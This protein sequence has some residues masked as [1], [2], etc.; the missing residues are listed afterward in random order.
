MLKEFIWKIRV[1]Y[2]DTD[3]GGVVFY[4]NYLRFM[5]RARTEWLR[6]IGFDHKNL[7]E[8]YKLIFAV[9]NLK[10]N[11]MK[12]GYLDDLLT[13]TSKLLNNRGASLVFQQEIINE[14][15][16][17]L[18]QA[19]VKIACLNSNTLKASPMPEKLLME[20]TNDS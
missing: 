8:K 11:Y 16:E 3:A 1:Y 7:I 13:I 5:E 10:I 9:K 6:D 4:A 12:P 19:E 15:D 14:K 20:L 17:L 18:T 2:E